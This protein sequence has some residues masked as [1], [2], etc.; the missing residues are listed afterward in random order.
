[1][2]AMTLDPALP[3][4]HSCCLCGVKWHCDQRGCAPGNVTLLCLRCDYDR[5][6]RE[7][8]S[9]ERFQDECKDKGSRVEAARER[10]RSAEIHLDRL[11]TAVAEVYGGFSS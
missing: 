1:M 6:E 11:R 8:S 2:R 7:L 4:R 3:G 9:A 10:V 5:A